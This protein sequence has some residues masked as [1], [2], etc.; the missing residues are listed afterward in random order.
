MPT[1]SMF[2]GI[3]IRMFFRDAEKHHVVLAV[4]MLLLTLT[5]KRLKSFDTMMNL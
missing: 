4:L 3:L 1:I 2:Y 5:M